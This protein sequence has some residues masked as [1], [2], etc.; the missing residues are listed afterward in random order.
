M[1]A[2]VRNPPL[3]NRRMRSLGPFAGQRLFLSVGEEW[4]RRLKEQE[5]DPLEKLSS[6]IIVSQQLQAITGVSSCDVTV[7]LEAPGTVYQRNLP[8]GQGSPASGSTEM[9]NPYQ[10]TWGTHRHIPQPRGKLPVLLLKV[11]EPSDRNSP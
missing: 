8:V 4:R 10:S 2:P 6:I 11:Q 3:V 5:Q 7:R 1:T 9:V